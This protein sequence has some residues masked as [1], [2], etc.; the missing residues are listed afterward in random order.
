KTRYITGTGLG[1]SIVK[2]IM[3]SLGGIIDVESEYGK[4]TVF[5]IILTVS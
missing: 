2:G 3:D 5:N 4:G 1:L